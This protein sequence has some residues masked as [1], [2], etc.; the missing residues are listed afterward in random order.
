M[1]HIRIKDTIKA[2]GYSIYEFIRY[3]GVFSF[4]PFI[5][6][7][8]NNTCNVHEFMDKNEPTLKNLNR[9]WKMWWTK[10]FYLRKLKKGWFPEYDWSGHCTLGVTDL[11][12]LWDIL[13]FEL[14]HKSDRMDIGRFM[15]MVFS[16]YQIKEKLEDEK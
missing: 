2:I 5:D 14:Y 9:A 7:R 11:K 15:R 12:K 3:L 10:S 8:I 1:I 13:S 16:F 4:E 6:A